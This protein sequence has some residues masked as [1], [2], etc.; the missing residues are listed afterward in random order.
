MDQEISNDE[1][2]GVSVHAGFPNPGEDSRLGNLD[3]NQLL[4]KYPA[5][6]FLFEVD[7]G[8]WESIGIFSGDVAVIDRALEIHKTDVVVWWRGSEFAISNASKLPASANVWGIVTAV[9]H[10]FRK[11][12]R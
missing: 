3:L 10:R 2:V 1:S 5:S 12:D 4:V 6:T 11:D 9:I 7:G 8:E